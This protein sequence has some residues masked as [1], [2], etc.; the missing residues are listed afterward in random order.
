MKEKS[1]IISP[2]KVFGNIYFVGTREAS[3][4]IID[5]GDGLILIDPGMPETFN[6]VLENIHTLGFN[7]SDVKII[8]L[9]HGHYDHAG[10][11]KQMAA[12]S[13]ADIYIGA[14]DVKMVNGEENTSL[15]E[16]FGVNFTGFFTPDVLLY[17]N[18][19]VSLGNTD[20]LCLS[21][22]GHTDGTMSFFFNTT[23]GKN[24]YLAGMHGGSGTNTLTD[25]FL[26]KHRLPF[27][28]RKKFIEGIKKAKEQRV[29]IFLGNHVGNNDTEGKLK[30]V[31]NGDENAFYAPEEWQ[32]FLDKRIERIKEISMKK[33]NE[34]F[35]KI[36]SLNE[37][38]ISFWI[39]VGNIESPTEFK[40]GVDAVGKYFCDYAKAQGF[41]TEVF[42]QS[43]AGNCVCITMNS[44]SKNEPI[45]L[46]GHID[47]VHPVGS[48]GSPAVKT[49]G[50]Y[51][52]GP[53]VTD[54]KGGTV[55]ALMAMTALKAVGFTERPV[56]LLLQ[57][58]EE[59]NSMSSSKETINYI[60]N[61]AKN[62]IAFLNCESTRGNTAVL[63]RKGLSRYEFE[64]TGK[65][66][67][68]SRCAEGGASAILEAAQKIIELEKWKEK[69]GVT[70][71]CGVIS[72]GTAAN[73][74]P[75]KCTFTAEIR[76]NTNAEL[77][78]AESIIKKI[79]E[80]QYIDG[81]S[82]ELKKIVSRPA[83]EK[84]DRNFELLK[85]MNEIYKKCGLP[86]LTARQ[87]LGGS[88]AAE[89]T[90]SGIPCVD[91]IGVAGDK[92]HTPDE[93]ALLSSLSQAAKRIA[94]VCFYI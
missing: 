77:E 47:T 85:K 17:D 60:C 82:C 62:S 75:E 91:S 42:E 39:D 45:T 7:I 10:S 55:A 1:E 81:T 92:I 66:I 32:T 76:F 83:M 68:A 89:V 51:L 16:L 8:L 15:A 59:N 58:D 44:D 2:E 53:G 86:E 20:I 31:S 4:H 5:T 57:S 84:C 11:A 69:D 27:S 30:K 23:D 70:C 37:E 9:S 61:K 56:R 3:T 12:I 49:E 93:Y 33:L 94:A 74:V 26:Q 40:V 65:S 72:G 38:F 64:I 6:T 36:D 48:F 79:A 52:Y 78:Y 73:T 41:D 35:A 90:Q 21:T 46:S 29:E 67:H 22:P 28:N 80:K 87:S 18:D 43:V 54:C 34:L 14:G 50:D 71:N 24:V 88:D 13:G 19:T 25:E 63:W